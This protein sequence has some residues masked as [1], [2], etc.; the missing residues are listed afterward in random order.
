MRRLLCGLSFQLL[1]SK[2]CFNVTPIFSGKS[3]VTGRCLLMVS[4][5]LRRFRVPFSRSLWKEGFPL[6]S[7]ETL[8]DPVCVWDKGLLSKIDTE[9][10]K[11]NHKKNQQPKGVENHVHTE[12]CHVFAT[13]LFIIVKT[14]KQPGCSSTGDG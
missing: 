6:L 1:L 12:T 9:V 8:T 7:V 5:F 2:G 11:L 14:W 4:C 3:S 10:R 13:A